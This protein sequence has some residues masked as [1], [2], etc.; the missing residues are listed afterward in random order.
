MSAAEG[1]QERQESM[2]AE[3][4]W[5]G[6]YHIPRSA[7]TP[8]AKYASLQGW[9]PSQNTPKEVS[10]WA[11]G[12][13]AFLGGVRGM[14]PNGTDKNPSPN[15]KGSMHCPCLVPT[16]KGPATWPSDLSSP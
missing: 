12:L 5:M 1:S 7:T 16:R 13:W 9:M 2:G 6:R 4:G 15:K 14:N 8:R 10:S 11:S 3:S